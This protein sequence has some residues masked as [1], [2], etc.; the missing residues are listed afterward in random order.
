MCEGKNQR[1][2]EKQLLGNYNPH[3]HGSEVSEIYKSQIFL[4]Y[5]LKNS[6]LVLA[7]PPPLFRGEARLVQISQDSTF[8]GSFGDSAVVP[9]YSRNY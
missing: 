9:I 1:E 7:V 2:T 3:G 5:I 4:T 8:F 6:E